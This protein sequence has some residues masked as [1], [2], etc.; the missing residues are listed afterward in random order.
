MN[1]AASLCIQAS[2]ELAKKGAEQESLLLFERAMLADPEDADVAIRY[3]HRVEDSIGGD[4]DAQIEQLES[5]EALAR[6]RVL[7]VAIHRVDDLVKRANALRTKREALI[8]A[9]Q[10]PPATDE[11]LGAV[12]EVLAL[13]RNGKLDHRSSVLG[14]DPVRWTRI[15]ERARDQL[16]ANAAEVPTINELIE[17]G[18]LAQ[19]FDTIGPEVRTA[20]ERISNNW[21][22]TPRAARALQHLD[23]QLGPLVA[24]SES[25][26]DRRAKALDGL[27]ELLHVAASTIASTSHRAEAMARW[28]KFTDEH[29]D[30]IQAALKF[31]APRDDSKADGSCQKAL[32]RTR[33]LLEKVSEVLP[34]LSNSS[35]FESAR[36]CA[37]K[38]AG[39]GTR[40]AQIQQRR[41]DRWA[42]HRIRAGYESGGDYIGVI[43]DE[44]KLGDS[45]VDNF[46]QIDMRFLSHEVQRCYSEVFD[47]L[48]ARLDK[49]GS[50]KD[51]DSRGNKLNVLSRMLDSEKLA[52]SNF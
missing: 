33:L 23:G 51:F 45:L 20:I 44:E 47:T 6:S 29:E 35:A 42:M 13:A 31:E 50:A 46:R 25:L 30:A 26:D 10:A 3:L 17:R 32:E 7:Y 2:L 22:N 39:A 14:G 21:R 24:A 5:L 49:P 8:R 40:I 41:Y 9:N 19:S 18:Q 38:L 34:S 27:L 52:P 1:E 36:E 37:A 43:D 15:L 4:L 11:D 48:Y 12:N 28:T 16:D